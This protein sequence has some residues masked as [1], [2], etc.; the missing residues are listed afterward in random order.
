MSIIE[1]CQNTDK[2][3]KMKE[4]VDRVLGVRPNITHQ[5]VADLV[6]PGCV[7]KETLRKHHIV[8]FYTRFVDDDGLSIMGFKIPKD[9][10]VQVR[11]I[12]CIL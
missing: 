12:N 3:E 4:E 7:F 10:E 6:Y 9:T 8:T 1:L 2:L 5:D 11:E